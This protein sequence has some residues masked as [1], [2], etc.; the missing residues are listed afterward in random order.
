MG[1][2]CWSR[3]GTRGTPPEPFHTPCSGARAL[4]RPLVSKMGAPGLSKS[5]SRGA[6]PFLSI[7]P[8]HSTVWGQQRRREVPAGPKAPLLKAQPRTPRGH[9]L[10]PPQEPQGHGSPRH[11]R[12]TGLGVPHVRMGH[13]PGP[14]SLAGGR[15]EP[16]GTEGHLVVSPE[17]LGV[18]RAA[19]ARHGERWLCPTW[20]PRSPPG[21]HSMPL[22]AFGLRHR[23]LT[24]RPSLQLSELIEETQ[25][26]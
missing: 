17:R 2:P 20:S 8:P 13:V 19:G 4:P 10:Q 14:C 6:R 15:A 24:S 7:L 26:R 5:T 23:R 18:L 12:G 11:Q 1:W 22:Q 25:A 16:C 3:A 9:Q 21:S